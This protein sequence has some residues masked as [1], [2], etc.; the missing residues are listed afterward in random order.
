MWRL[1]A[2]VDMTSTLNVKSRFVELAAYPFIVL[3]A[4]E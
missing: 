4:I 2:A 3:N 1:K